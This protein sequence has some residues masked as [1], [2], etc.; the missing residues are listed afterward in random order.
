LRFGEVD[1]AA[2]HGSTLRLGGGPV[3][4]FGPLDERDRV[5]V[6]IRLDGLAIRQALSRDNG[7]SH[8]ERW[9]PGADVVL[10]GAWV[11]A[12]PVAIVMGLGA[13]VAFGPTR[14]LVDNVTVTSLPVLRFVGEIGVRF[15]F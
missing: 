4:L 5:G 9:T 12:L 14:V 10:E 1:A 3:L 11:V 15:S 13:E 8:G 2:A 7:P 6:A